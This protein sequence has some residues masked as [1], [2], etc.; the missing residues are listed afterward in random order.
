MNKRKIAAMDSQLHATVLYLF[1]FV[2]TIGND[3]LHGDKLESDT[4]YAG[5]LTALLSVSSVQNK[6]VCLCAPVNVAENVSFKKFT[7]LQQIEHC[8]FRI[9]HF[10]NTLY[11]KT[12]CVIMHKFCFIPNPA[13]ALSERQI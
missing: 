11:F 6:P 2:F 7:N 5:R 8:M 12:H 1:V 10:S 9:K 4:I 3:E 13:C